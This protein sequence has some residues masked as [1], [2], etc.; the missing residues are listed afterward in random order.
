MK[1]ILNF[2]K[3]LCEY[4]LQYVHETIMNQNGEKWNPLIPLMNEGLGELM[5]RRHFLEKDL[6]PGMNA[7]VRLLHDGELSECYLWN[8]DGCWKEKMS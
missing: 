2:F 8:E 7:V 4:F 3:M 1:D 5:C 6:A